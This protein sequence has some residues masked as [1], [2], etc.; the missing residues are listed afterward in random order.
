MRNQEAPHSKAQRRCGFGSGDRTDR[1]TKKIKA[2][3]NTS[4]MSQTVLASCFG[5]SCLAAADCCCTPPLPS[6][7]RPTLLLSCFGSF[8][9]LVAPLPHPLSYGV[10]SHGGPRRIEGGGLHTPTADTPSPFPAPKSPSLVLCCCLLLQTAPYD[11]KK[12][13]ASSPPASRFTP[14]DFI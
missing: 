4:P 13:T 2:S 7:P 6:A 12:Q 3:E 11:G 10:L 14:P 5:P 9:L 1:K 8:A